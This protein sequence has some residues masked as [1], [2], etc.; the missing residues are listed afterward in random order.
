MLI[1][2]ECIQRIVISRLTDLGL[3]TLRLPLSA[4]PGEKHVPILCSSDLGTANRI[5]LILGSPDQELGIW[6]YR[7][8]AERSMDTGSMVNI[9][10]AVLGMKD[11]ESEEG[12]K[13]DDTALVIA[14]TGQLVYHCGSGKA[15]SQR[16]WLTLPVESAV[17]PPLKQ[18]Y[19]NVIPRNTNWREHVKCI[20]EDILD[21]G[22][23]MVKPKAK[24]DIIGVEEGGLA[25]AEYLTDHCEFDLFLLSYD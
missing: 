12:E 22:S 18:T 23:K 13:H 21:P 3:S 1:L 7:S 6:T 11:K 14:N 10:K 9:T 2:T 15:I 16:T 17:H 20:F 4:Q 24:I 8:I 25:A 5:I 19:R